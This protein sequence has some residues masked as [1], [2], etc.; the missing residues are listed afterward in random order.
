MN[1]FTALHRILVISIFFALN[2]HYIFINAIAESFALIPLG[3]A[4]LTG[5]LGELLLTLSAGLFT[6]AIQLA[7]PVLVALLFTMGALGLA[8][9]TVPQ[10][11]VF[12]MSFPISFFVGLLIY[13]AS[14]P[15][16]P[17]WLTW[18]FGKNNDDIMTALVTL[19]PRG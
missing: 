16:L 7:A 14:F 15:F 8:A 12:V 6:I 9:R 13:I 3:Y 19:R 17:E 18:H 5:S 2:L 10:L 11:N 1:S 4:T